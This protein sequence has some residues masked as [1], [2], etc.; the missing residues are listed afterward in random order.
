MNIKEIIINNKNTGWDITDTGLVSDRFD[1]YS[2]GQ[3]QKGYYR[4]SI[5]S[6]IYE[7]HRLVWETFVGPI[8]DGYVIH[9]KN[10][11]KA[12]NRLENLEL[13]SEDEHRK[14]HKESNITRSK[15]S[16]KLSGTNNP[17]FGKESP[18]R[19][20]IDML[21]MNGDYIKTFSDSCTAGKELGI[22]S[23]HIGSV[24]NGKRASAGGYKWRHHY[25]K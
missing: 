2:Y 16:K 21:T 8:E 20:A 4:I 13:L 24:C 7:V 5:D 19:K 22:S 18:N 25:D 6:K 15:L 9:H 10:H 23:T 11:I 3:L 1:R 14:L 12:D 17:M